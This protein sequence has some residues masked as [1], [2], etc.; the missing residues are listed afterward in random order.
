MLVYDSAYIYI[1]SQKTLKDRITAIEAIINAL[2]DTA[3]K[4]AGN[5]DVEEYMLDDGQTK[6]KT[7]YKGVDDIVDSIDAFEKLLQRLYNQLNGRTVRL[8][9][10][11]SM[12]RGGRC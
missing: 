4:A 5:D 11:R 6:I 9:D 3:L 10:Y 7:V 2:Y 8:V 1:K 12:K